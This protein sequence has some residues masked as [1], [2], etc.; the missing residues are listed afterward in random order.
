MALQVSAVQTQYGYRKKD[1]SDISDAL[2]ILWCREIND[3]TYR[4]MIDVNPTKYLSTQT[5]SV[6]SGTSSY[7]LNSD[8]RDATTFGCGL[9]KTD[10]NGN[11]LDER[12]PVTGYGSQT[13][14]YYFSGSSLIITPT[15]TASE[16][17]KLR[18][19]PNNTIIDA[20]ADYFTVD[21]LSTGTDIIPERYLEYV[22]N[23]LDVRYAI[24]DDVPEDE[25]IADQR[26]VRSLN[27]L[28]QAIKPDGEAYSMP[29][30][31]YNY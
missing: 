13:L 22:L 4:Y 18:Y 24:W 30:F 15:P 8:F 21:T 14:G 5:I 16:T 28:A 17:Y 11:P 25:A 6:T 2:F 27:E 31:T 3:F 20:T 26:F 7:A 29:E 9:Y 19:I 12:L 10:S 23:A 1:I